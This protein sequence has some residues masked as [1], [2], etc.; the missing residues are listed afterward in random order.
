MRTTF[1]R[2]ALFLLLPAVGC[3]ALSSDSGE[4]R[5]LEFTAAAMESLPQVQKNAV[6]MSHLLPVPPPP[7]EVASDYLEL[8]KFFKHE[9]HMHPQDNFCPPNVDVAEND[10]MNDTKFTATTLMGLIYHAEMYSG[11]QRTACDHAE[12]SIDGQAFT[13]AS[14]EGGD[15][16]RFILDNYG[17]YTC[18]GEESHNGSTTY[19]AYSTAP[20]YQASLTTRHRAGSDKFDFDQTDVFQVYVGLDGGA[21]TTLAFNW[22]GISSMLGRAIVLVNL[23]SHRFVVKYLTGGETN[24]LVTAVGIG[25][26]DRATGAPHPGHFWASFS[27]DSNGSLEVLERCVDNVGQL[28]EADVTPCQEEGIPV[29]WSSRDELVAFLELDAEEQQ[30]LAAFLSKLDTAEPLPADEV[31]Q[32]P[33]DADKYFPKSMK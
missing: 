7:F 19:V 10:G 32:S 24:R 14:S 18:V 21:P 20:D 8:A 11:G 27:N 6:D 5:D 31:P 30:R 3:D 26:I 33:D 22:A 25:G 2:L 28:I 23:E 13:A 12:G 16:D 9:C 29:D 1:L 4:A 15:P 17:L